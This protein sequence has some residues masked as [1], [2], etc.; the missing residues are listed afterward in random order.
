MQ[1]INYSLF[2]EVKFSYPC[3]EEPNVNSRIFIPSESR[4]D[5]ISAVFDMEG[6]SFFDYNESPIPTLFNIESPLDFGVMSSEI[7][8]ETT[9][10]GITGSSSP[11]RDLAIKV[12]M[13]PSILKL[14]VKD[15]RRS[16]KITIMDE[17]KATNPMKNIKNLPTLPVISAFTLNKKNESTPKN[18]VEIKKTGEAGNN[19]KQKVIETIPENLKIE[20][21][22]KR[23]KPPIKDVS[24]KRTNK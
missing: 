12:L 16:N 18:Q 1:L 20:A 3:E 5:S 13:S 23:N 14:S 10:I 17:P 19:R 7:T 21:N 24:G 4:V 15:G 22:N 8:Q 11:G 6:A 2:P 9:E